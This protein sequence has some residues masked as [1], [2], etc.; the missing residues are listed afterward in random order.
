MSPGLAISVANF[1]ANFLSGIINISSHT[2]MSVFCISFVS[3]FIIVSLFSVSGSS[4]VAIAISAY[5][6][7]IFHISGLLVLSL[8]HGAQKTRINLFSHFRRCKNCSVLSKA[9]G[10]C[11]KSTK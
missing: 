8:F 1:I 6:Q 2:G 7:A 5:F 9:S 3:S 4:S 11:A 10:E